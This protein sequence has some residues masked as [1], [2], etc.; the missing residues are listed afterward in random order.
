MISAQLYAGLYG[1][2]SREQLYLRSYHRFYGLEDQLYTPEFLAQ[3]GP[4]GP[5][6]GGARTVSAQRAGQRRFSTASGSR[7]FR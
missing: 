3:V 5:A 6:A 7:T 4:P 1:E 2:D